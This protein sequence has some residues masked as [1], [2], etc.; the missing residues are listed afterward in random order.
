[1]II[2]SAQRLPQTGL[3]GGNKPAAKI[4]GNDVQ[5]KSWQSA[6]GTGAGQCVDE[7]DDAREKVGQMDQQLVTTLTDLDQSR[8]CV[9][10]AGNT[11]AS[12]GAMLAP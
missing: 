10:R 4:H 12:F 7:G 11:V 3:F 6:L 2:E 8:R 9:W 1:V 5:A